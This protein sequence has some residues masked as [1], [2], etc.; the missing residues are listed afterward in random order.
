MSSISHCSAAILSLQWSCFSRTIA[1][2]QYA[3]SPNGFD[4]PPRDWNSFGLQTYD[5]GQFK[6]TQDTALAECIALANRGLA[7]DGYVYCSIDSGWS[8]GLH[9]D[10]YGRVVADEAVFPDMKQLGDDLHS[11]GLK[12]GIYINVI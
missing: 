3:T 10:E 4:A 6:L 9:G 5:Q 11:R 2:L 12:L 1:I 8:I 7:G